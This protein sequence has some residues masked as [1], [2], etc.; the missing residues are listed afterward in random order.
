MKK[1]IIILIILLFIFINFTN[2]QEPSCEGI[3]YSQALYQLKST[4]YNYLSKNFN[5]AFIGPPVSEIKGKLNAL[6]NKDSCKN[7]DLNWDYFYGF[8]QDTYDLVLGD[9]LERGMVSF[10]LQSGLLG[11]RDVFYLI[12]VFDKNHKWAQ[13]LR[14]NP[15]AQTDYCNTLS[16]SPL[17][18]PIK[19]TFS[20]LFTFIE[21][22]NKLNTNLKE[23]SSLVGGFN[24][25]PAGLKNYL[26][27]CNLEL[28]SATVTCA[29]VNLNKLLNDRP[30]PD[31]F[32]EE[33]L[34]A[35]LG[36]KPAKGNIDSYFFK[37]EGWNLFKI[38]PSYVI[39]YD[40]DDF[41]NYK[42]FKVNVIQPLTA[43][44]DQFEGFIKNCAAWERG[45]KDIKILQNTLKPIEDILIKEYGG[46]IKITTV[47]VPIAV[48]PPGFFG[49][50]FS[51]ITP[52][53]IFDKI[54]GF[55]F[56]LAPYVFTLLLIIGGLLYL[57]T[58]VSDQIR[59]GSEVIKWAI[60]GYFLL[61][62]ITGVVTLL[63]TVFGGP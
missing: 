4:L 14:A 13:A 33:K 37:H 55:L 6:L 22:Y 29:L 28:K 23:L 17:K 15:D 10:T 20:N 52:E 21:K 31:L 34:K 46:K 56:D 2:A 54:K 1:I 9:P 50:E 5:F 48:K 41:K 42:N 38:D 12:F 40:F 58:P 7:L 35:L 53:T 24:E 16:S 26:R 36:G 61:L 47:T 44:N 11:L 32:D 39:Y 59:K 27:N 57:I 30:L 63:K 49:K 19:S 60:I 25:P 18:T 43:F 51:E 62:V 3:T 8:N 45:G